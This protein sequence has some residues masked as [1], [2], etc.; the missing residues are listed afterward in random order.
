MNTID[1]LKT[2]KSTRAYLDTPV[3]REK[4]EA[5]LS[6]ARH[7]PSGTNAQPWQVAVVSG[8]QKD[9]LSREMENLFRSGEMGEMDYQYYPLKW[10]EPFKSRRLACGRQLYSTLNIE[11]KDKEKRYE[12]WVAN[13]HGF[14]APVLL[15]F[16]L[17]P[18]MQTGSFLDYGMF[19]QSI[20]LAAVEEG[21]ATC[22]QAALGQYPELIKKRLGYPMDHILICGMALG[23]EDKNAPVNNYRTPR[24][25]LS[26]F[27]RFF[28]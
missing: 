24:E 18:V 15:F 21:L 3:P 20:M 5:V 9:E 27:T 12:Q 19:L 4:I 16:F 8:R 14:G 1:A 17:D 6:A 25:E 26:V 7:A 28:D 2:R 22:S 11:R 13:Y 10:P 23:Y